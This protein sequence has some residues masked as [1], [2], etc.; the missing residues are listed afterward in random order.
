MLGAEITLGKRLVKIVPFG[1][2]DSGYVELSNQSNGSGI[3]RGDAVRFVP[4][5]ALAA[6]NWEDYR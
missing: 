2:G 3:V 5:A 6:E 1:E 4:A